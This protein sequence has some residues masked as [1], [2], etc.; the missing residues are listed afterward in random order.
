MTLPGATTFRMNAATDVGTIT[1]SF[2]VRVIRSG[3]GATANG[4][5]GAAPQATL[6]LRANAGSI[7]LKRSSQVSFLMPHQESGATP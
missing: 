4:E 1:T 3:T 7:S 2:P 5:V 6:T